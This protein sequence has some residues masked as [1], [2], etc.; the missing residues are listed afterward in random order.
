M[1]ILDD[2]KYLYIRVMEE[3]ICFS[4]LCC[5]CFLSCLFL[6]HPGAHVR[7]QASQS[8]NQSLFVLFIH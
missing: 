7:K 2:D 4:L 3:I 1:Y 8:V 5:Y 6:T